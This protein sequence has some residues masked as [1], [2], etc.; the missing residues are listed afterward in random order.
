MDFGTVTVS[1]S[2]TN[3]VV[4]KGT[5]L[6]SAVT[7]TVSGTGFR[8]GA[9]TLS[10]AKV[11]STAGAQLQVLFKEASAGSYTGTLTL[12]TGTLTRKVSLKARIADAGQTATPDDDGTGSGSGSGSGTGSGSAQTGA[13]NSNIPANYYKAADY[14]SDVIKSRPTASLHANRADCY[15]MLKRLNDA[16]N[17]IKRPSSA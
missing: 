16:A 12:K 5:N 15:L 11:N 10:A 9:T 3:T 8:V 7:V 17:D 6:T 13:T 14:F 1:K 4:V 2:K